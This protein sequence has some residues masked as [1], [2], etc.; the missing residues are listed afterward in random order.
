MKKI[1]LFLLAAGLIGGA[2]GYY[3]WNKP[4]E[5]MGTAKAAATLSAAQ[6][7]SE[8]TADETAA[9]GKYL[10]QTIAISGQVKE[11]TDEGGVVKVMLEAGDENF[12]V[13]CTF[14]SAFQHPRRAFPV[15]ES[16]TFKGKCDGINLD[17]QLSRC[18]EQK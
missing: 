7:L 1:L 5:D 8:Y 6:L 2:Y 10:G 15:G 9:N 14:D 18:V 13:Y 4:H 17:V 16:V 3:L 11:A 12:G